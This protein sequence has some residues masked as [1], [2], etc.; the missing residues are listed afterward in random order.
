MSEVSKLERQVRL[1]QD[2]F[3]A[4]DRKAV[5]QV[6]ELVLPVLKGRANREYGLDWDYANDAAIDAIM[7]VKSRGPNG[8]TKG[9]SLMAMFNVA[10]GWHATKVRT[11]NGPEQ[12]EVDFGF[13][14]DEDSDDECEPLVE[15]ETMRMREGAL[16]H[17]WLTAVTITTPEDLVMTDNMLQ[18]FE[19]V[20]RE[21]CGVR[22][23][24]VYF[25]VVVQ[26]SPQDVVAEKY[27]LTQ[28]RVSQI[29]SEV[30]DVLRMDLGL[31]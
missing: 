15:V 13:T 20:A 19:R 14:P 29:V 21:K 4:D 2:A 26:E 12:V 6:C 16:P 7:Y 28:A 8:F 11:G 17:E 24:N 1:L 10:L 22:N 27:T 31:K 3:L 30:Q 23:W 9:S 25:D 18:R 5:E